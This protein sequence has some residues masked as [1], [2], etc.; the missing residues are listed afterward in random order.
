MFK[1][2][3]NER[4]TEDRGKDFMDTRQYAE[5]LARIA[6]RDTDISALK[7]K[8][9]SLGLDVTNLYN[10]MSQKLRDLQREHKEQQN[11]KNISDEYL[12]FG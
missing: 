12:P 5:L 7:S 3:N 11:E 4:K 10:K 1:F 6:E 9:A 2:F 8:V